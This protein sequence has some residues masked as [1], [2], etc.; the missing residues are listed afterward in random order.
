MY[1]YITFL[2][3]LFVNQQ[4]VRKA[5]THKKKL[6]ICPCC[7]YF[8]YRGMFGVSA[9][10]VNPKGNN[11]MY[12]SKVKVDF[13]LCLQDFLIFFVPTIFFLDSIIFPQKKF[14]DL[15][16]S[17]IP[18]TNTISF[19]STTST[20]STSSIPSTN[21][22]STGLYP[23]INFRLRLF[24]IRKTAFWTEAEST[25]LFR[26]SLSFRVQR[27]IVPLW[28]F[29]FCHKFSGLKCLSFVPENIKQIL[30]SNFIG[31]EEG[32]MGA[33]KKKKPIGRKVGRF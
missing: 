12:D 16:L 29:E 31:G 21:R 2:H 32:E 19:F 8:N 4:C 14:G 13:L 23:H 24:Q 3:L 25:F 1:S 28:V 15:I 5:I 27:N 33:R 10:F 26:F 22:R 30:Y 20:T 11:A 6:R 18:P 7:P 17:N 9:I